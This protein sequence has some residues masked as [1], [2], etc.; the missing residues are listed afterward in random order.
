MRSVQVFIFR[1]VRDQ[2]EPDDLRGEV[3][4]VASG[5][6]R[7]FSNAQEMLALLHEMRGDSTGG[8][9]AADFIELQLT[10]Q[11]KKE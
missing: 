5:E 3:Q 2:N 7:R 10:N 1:I 11:T 4:S 8:E 9:N 6:V